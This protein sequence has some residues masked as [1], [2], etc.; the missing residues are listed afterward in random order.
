MENINNL[1]INVKYHVNKWHRLINS[2]LFF[3]LALFMAINTYNNFHLNL[4][5]QGIF[6]AGLSFGLLLYT[7]II[8]NKL[9]E[10]MEVKGYY[11]TVE[12]T[13]PNLPKKKVKAFSKEKTDELNKEIAQEQKEIINQEIKELED[14]EFSDEH[15]K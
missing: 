4:M 7:W 13:T 9:E 8:F 6:S 1:K 14:R 15:S 10:E 5:W 11:Y 12:D 2:G 3:V